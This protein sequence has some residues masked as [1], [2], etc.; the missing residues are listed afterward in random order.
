MLDY[1]CTSDR[2]EGENRVRTGRGGVIVRGCGASPGE[3][4]GV[5]RRVSRHPPAYAARLAGGR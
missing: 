5:S 4:G 1:F 2:T 3:P